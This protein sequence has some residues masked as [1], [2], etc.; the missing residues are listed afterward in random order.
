MS[1]ARLSSILFGVATLASGI[2]NL[3]FP[4]SSLAAL[5]F[6]PSNELR[7]MHAASSVAALVMG[8][9]YILLGYLNIRV[10]FWATLPVRSVTVVVTIQLV[11]GGV[12]PKEFA[13]VPITEAI[14]VG[15]TATGLLVDKWRED[16]GQVGEKRFKTS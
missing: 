14:G 13:A 5:G 16:S 12:A 10:F 4:S 2:S 11:R 9:Y 7:T 1:L 6:V 8:T 15:L 3:L